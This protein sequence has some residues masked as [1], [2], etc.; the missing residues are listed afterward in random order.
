MIAR[1]RPFLAILLPLAL[2][3]C[4]NGVAASDVPSL[5]DEL[6]GGT[7]GQDP[8]LAAVVQDPIMTDPQLSTRSNADAIRPPSQPYAAPVPATDIA[9]TP[10]AA[11]GDLMKTPEAAGTCQQ[12][13]VARDAITLGALA[14][15]QRD[16]ATKT[17]AASLRYAAGW[18]NQ[19]PADIPLYGGARVIEAAGTNN[20]GCHVRAVTFATTQSADHMLDWYYTH[21]SKAGF[22]TE[23]GAD[24]TE[25]VLM[26]SRA[27][28][29]AAYM[30]FVREAPG[31]GSQIDLLVN[32]RP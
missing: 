11:D 2:A 14:A 19:L 22:T 16:P 29:G 27:R 1:F 18:A 7:N 30:A 3:A 10:D 31:G 15:R 8:L 25:H 26:G 13:A 20:A 21:A 23:H 28:D 32:T 4:G 24:G 9:A 12:C 5:D 17:C 6:A